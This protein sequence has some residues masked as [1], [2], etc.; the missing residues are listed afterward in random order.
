MIS[1]SK[2]RSVRVWDIKRGCCTHVFR[3]HDSIV[4]CLEIVEHED[5]EY[6]VSGS[7]DNTLRVWRLPDECIFDDKHEKDQ[8]ALVYHL[9]EENP[10]FV[11]VLRGHKDSVR[12]LSGYGNIVISGSYD[13]YVIV[14]DIALM[15]C[16]FILAGHIGRVYCVLY[17]HERHRCISSGMD[18]TIRIWDLQRISNH[19]TI[20]VVRRSLH[21][22]KTITGSISTLQ[23]HTPIIG[24]LRLSDTFLVSAAADGSIKFLDS[25]DYSTR[26]C[27]QHSGQPSINAIMAPDDLLVSG[28]EK[29]LS[30]HNLRNGKVVHTNLLP[31][32]EQIWEVYFK[33]E[34]LIVAIERGHKS[35]VEILD[36]GQRALSSTS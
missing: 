11:G 13:K 9:S 31:D 15:R 8:G 33:R 35:Y 10:Y 21:P 36:F 26:I 25:N 17:D 16:L 30:V 2:D 6:I 32:A 7:K 5:V 20:G 27:F 12:T 24:L 4:R 22:C 34:I 1:G 14:W 29:Q 19:G 28:S 18:A 3:G 23:G